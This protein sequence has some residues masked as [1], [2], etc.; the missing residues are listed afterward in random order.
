MNAQHW[1][2]LILIIPFSTLCLSHI[3]KHPE[4]QNPSRIRARG[5]T[6]QQ[7]SY[8][9]QFI[10]ALPRHLKTHSI[11]SLIVRNPGL[12][13]TLLARCLLKRAELADYEQMLQEKIY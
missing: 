13:S 5:Q 9:Q 6:I 2:S 8:Y 3:K 7:N 1:L 10:Q 4:I 12:Y 11:T